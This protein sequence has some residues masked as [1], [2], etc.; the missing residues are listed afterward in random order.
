M[1][2]EALMTKDVKTCRHNEQRSSD[3]LGLL[4][5]FCKDGLTKVVWVETIGLELAEIKRVESHRPDR[6]LS[7]K[8]SSFSSLFILFSSFLLGFGKRSFPPSSS[9]LFSSQKYTSYTTGFG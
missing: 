7:Q 6:R 1:Q 5:D 2:V 8:T 9:L 4:L 3:P